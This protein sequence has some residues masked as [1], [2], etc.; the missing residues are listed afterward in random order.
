MKQKLLNK[1]K[2][3]RRLGAQRATSTCA[4]K[5][6]HEKITLTVFTRT[7]AASGVAA[8]RSRSTPTAFA[9]TGRPPHPKATMPA[10][11]D[12][13]IE[14]REAFIHVFSAGRRSAREEVV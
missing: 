4:D 5:L 3:R 1:A 12:L 9:P 8:L 13:P 14:M 2:R 11:R 7:L 10:W 6:A